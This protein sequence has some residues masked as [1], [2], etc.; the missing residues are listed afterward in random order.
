MA[1]ISQYMQ[2][3]KKALRL[4]AMA[5]FMI[6]ASFG[7]GLTGAILPGSRERYMNSE[8]K[9]EQVDKREDDEEQEM[10]VKS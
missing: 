8:I 9:T 10:K 2:K 5:L 3:I 6:L 4:L 7:L 1:S